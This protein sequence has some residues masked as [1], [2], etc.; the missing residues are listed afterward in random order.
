MTNR[1]V[2]SD[3]QSFLLLWLEEQDGKWR[4]LL[5][6]L[7]DVTINKEITVDEAVETLDRYLWKD[8]SGEWLHCIK[9]SD[10]VTEYHWDDILPRSR[11][12]T[13]GI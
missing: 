7:G 11:R 6:V 2:I 13:G 4:L 3:V 9:T 8:D 1:Y 12:G 5:H 10:T